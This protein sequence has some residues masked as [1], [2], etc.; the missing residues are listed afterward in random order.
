MA[1]DPED[2]LRGIILTALRRH[3]EESYA[4]DTK[5]AADSVLSALADEIP[6]GYDDLLRSLAE[7][8]PGG[9]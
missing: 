1:R 2:Q 5:G 9:A 8:Q 4:G 6:D 7:R 3:S